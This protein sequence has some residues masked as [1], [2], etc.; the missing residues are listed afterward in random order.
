MHPDVALDR[1]RAAGV[2]GVAVAAP[3]NPDGTVD[4]IACAR[5]MESVEDIV[6][7]ESTGTAGLRG[8]SYIAV[9]GSARL[10]DDGDGVTL[11][12]RGDAHPIWLG[13]DPFAA[14]D[15]VAG[16]VGLGPDADAPAGFTGGLVGVFGYDLG[17]RAEPT[18]QPLS[19]AHHRGLPL[20]DLHL[21]EVV[22]A[23]APDREAATLWTRP[24]VRDDVELDEVA[25]R[26]TTALAG[27]EH[28]PPLSQSV[29]PASITSTT[30]LPP[31]A[32]VEAVRH[33]LDHIG[34]GDV[35][36]VNLSQT[37]RAR[38]EGDV[39]DL[40]RALRR[41]SPAEFGATA[42]LGDARIASISP[43]T[44]L[45]CVGRR[46]MTRPIKGTRPRREDPLADQA[47]R[48]ALVASEKDR[49]ENVMV[50]D[51]ERNDLGRVCQVGSVTVP[52]LVVVEAHPTVW[53]LVSTVVGT[54]RADV[55]YGEL[56]RATFP[57]GSVTGTPKVRAMQIIE[58]L[59]P[60]RRGAY[61]GAI[62]FV[63]AGCLGTSVAIRTATLFPGGD[64]EYG[65]GGGIVADSD[66]DAELQESLDKAA[67]FLAAVGAQPAQ[68]TSR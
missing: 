10:I 18:S 60:V 68:E 44:F 9:I 46:V 36:Q 5:A 4:L 45:A 26:V 7:L 64:V 6:V 63:G 61:C 12:L 66:P 51:M 43:E 33:V 11:R 54:L 42:P 27:T 32:Y 19:T 40:Y 47:E 67:A 55:G 22:L 16:R 37:I 21:A 29:P 50:V 25:Q 38:W 41:E 31:S 15:L 28:I 1:L 53:H 17:R 13:E 65:A 35:F 39:V 34:A 8:T 52:E 58:E 3:R 49:A 23:I 2:H 57:C 62:G 14:I 30:S 20:L 48:D 24:M 59:E 56:L